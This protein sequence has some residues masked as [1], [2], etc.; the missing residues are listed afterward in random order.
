MSDGVKQLQH[1]DP[2]LGATTRNKTSRGRTLVVYD[3]PDS[4]YDSTHTRYY[5]IYIDVHQRILT[6]VAGRTGEYHNTKP[7]PIH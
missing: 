2:Y 4:S 5:F 7:G 1:P 6:T 3:H